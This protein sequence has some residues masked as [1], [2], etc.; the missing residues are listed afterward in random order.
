[1]LPATPDNGAIVG[2]GSD[3]AVVDVVDDRGTADVVVDDTGT[4][5]FGDLDGAE[6]E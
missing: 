1:M 2:T 3:G 6:A 5:R 4:G